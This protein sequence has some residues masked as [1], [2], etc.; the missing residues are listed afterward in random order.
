MATR[1]DWARRVARWEKSGLTR[2]EFAAREG[3]KATTLGWWRSALRRAAA[4]PITALVPQAM[5]FVE[6]AS[7]GVEAT[8]ERIEVEL[9]NG[10]V[11]RVPASFDEDALRR[12]LAVAEGA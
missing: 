8:H 3:V 5:S 10:R 6:V 1:A 12:V 2:S 7:V 9:R 4:E 11:V